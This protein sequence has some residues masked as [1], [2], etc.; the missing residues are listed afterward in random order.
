MPWYKAPVTENA[1]SPPPLTRATK[2]WYAL[3]QGAEGIKNEAF[4][5]LLLFYYTSV[6]GLSGELA[7]LAILIALLFDA[8]TDPLVGTLSDRLDSRWGRRHPFLYGGAIPLGLFFYL[9]FAPP[10]G[11]GQTEIFA[12]LTVMTVATRASMTLFHVPHLSLGAELSSDYEERTHI[13]TLQYL[14][15]RF[16][17]GILGAFA[18]LWF[19]RATPAYAEGRFNPA[20]Y[21]ALA[22]TFAIVMVVWILLSAWRTRQRIPYLAKPERADEGRGLASLVLGDLV[23]S[24]R[25]ASFRALFIGL[26]LTYVAWGVTVSLGLH[27]ATYFWRASNEQLLVYGILTAI[28]IFVGLPFW[29]RVADRLDKKP[30]FM[31]GLTIFTA[32]IVGPAVCKLAGFWPAAGSDASVYLWGLTSGMVAHFGIASTMVTARSMMADVTDQDALEHGQRRE[33]I[34]FGAVS[35]AGKAAFGLGGL[36]AGAV[37]SAVGLL[38]QQAPETVGADVV[39]ALGSTLAISILALCGGSLLFF[40]RYQLTRERHAE[41]QA[42]LA[43]RSAEA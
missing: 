11:L 1:A 31:L 16:G 5:L 23:A 22:L 36:I 38:P 26:A 32:F 18:F 33:G 29:Q 17:H 43:L 14:Y 4:S 2:H 21:P 8:V 27:L 30:T 40:S 37:Y 24:L 12:W 34:F 41:I 25:N 35:F 19:F 39:A 10:A 15:A 42:Q 13:V 6:L 3:G 7:G 28:G 9:V 20:A